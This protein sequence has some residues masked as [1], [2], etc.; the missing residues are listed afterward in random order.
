[1][2]AIASAAAITPA[3]RVAISQPGST[4]TATTPRL[5]ANAVHENPPGRQAQRHARGDAHDRH[6]RRLPAHDG[7]ELA[8][9][10]PERLEQAA[11]PPPPVGAGHQQVRQRG[12]AAQRDHDAEQ[13]REVSG[14][15]E[16]HQRGG[17]AG[18]SRRSPGTAWSRSAS[19]AASGGTGH[20]VHKHPFGGTGRGGLTAPPLAGRLPRRPT[21]GG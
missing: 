7:G 11:L 12:R 13:Q 10:E 8:P 20:G 4:T 16:A 21:L 1:M 6:S 3:A 18:A 5:R 17:N 15:A 9:D 2:T 14:L 19:A